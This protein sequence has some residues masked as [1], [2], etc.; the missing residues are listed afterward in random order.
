M[1]VASLPTRNGHGFQGTVSIGNPCGCKKAVLKCEMGRVSRLRIIFRLSMTNRLTLLS[2]CLAVLVAGQL[3][4]APAQ[5]IIDDDALEEKLS[6]S[7]LIQGFGLP[8]IAAEDLFLQR[9][10]TIHTKEIGEG[11][12]KQLPRKD[13]D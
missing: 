7:H 4:R 3:A 10:K 12:G 5:G 11:V 1:V 2:S 9:L 13:L 8:R 6:R